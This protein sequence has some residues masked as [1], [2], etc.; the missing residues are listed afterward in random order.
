MSQIRGRF[1]KDADKS[2]YSYSSSIHYDWRLYPYDIAG[3]TVHARMLA[4]QDIITE[5]EAETIVKGLI[6]IAGEISRG[7]FQF[8]PELEDIHM[9]IESRL[10]EKVGDVGKKLHTARSR[11]DQIVLDIRLYTKDAIAHTITGI[12][13]LQ[14]TLVELAAANKKTIIPGYTHMQRAQPVLLAHHFLAYFEMLGR[15]IERFY[16]CM[17]RVDVLPLGSGALAGVAYNIDRKF[18]AKELGFGKISQNSLDAVADRDFIIEYEAD[19]SLCMMHLSR[20][21]E[22]IVLWSSSEFD[23]VELDDA[24]ATGSSIMPQKKNPDVAELARGKTGRVYGNLIA[25]LTTMKGLP[26]AY[27]RDMQEDKEGFFDTVD[28]L[29]ATLDVFK[30][31]LET[32]HIK[33]DKMAYAARQGYLLATDLADYLVKKG[34]PF[35]AAHEATGKLVTYA[36]KKGKSLKDL[37]IKEYQNFSAVFDKDVYK[38]TVESSVAGRDNTGGTAYKQ[39]AKQIAAARRKLKGAISED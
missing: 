16:D 6:D 36:I 22:E 21:A 26:L 24:Y 20:L 9:N 4:K 29:M 2:V 11:N 37:T 25:I 17:E 10:I 1:Q 15:D 8:K 32:V 18:L 23:F 33:T 13:E 14:N 28:T 38:I 7:K 3:S 19:A 12:V 30:G 34:M 5:P 35:R 31:M 27:N 39:V